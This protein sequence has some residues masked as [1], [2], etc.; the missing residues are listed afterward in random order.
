MDLCDYCAEKCVPQRLS[1]FSY[2]FIVVSCF[3]ANGLLEFIHHYFDWPFVFL[4]CEM[5]NYQYLCLREHSFS[6]IS[7]G[8]AILVTF[9]CRKNT[10]F[11]RF[12]ESTK[13]HGAVVRKAQILLICVGKS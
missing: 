9:C 5:L 1:V 3:D 6:R 12:W 8:E 4:F 10:K 11:H 2:V 13:F 7:V